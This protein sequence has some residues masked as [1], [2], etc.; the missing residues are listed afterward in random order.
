MIKIAINNQQDYITNIDELQNFFQSLANKTAEI[1]GYDQ[2]EISFALVDDHRIEKLN[3]KYRNK[4]TPTDV[5]SFSMDEKIWGDIV[6]SVERARK[7]A[8][9]Y[10]HDLKRELGYLAVHGIL[11]LLGYDH[12]NPGDRAEMRQK[13]ERV[14]GEF[15]LQRED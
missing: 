7:Q 3:E 1:E 6:I 12:K 10:G 2:G 9:E 14:L 4:C 13:E 5:L 8:E 11:H 15:N